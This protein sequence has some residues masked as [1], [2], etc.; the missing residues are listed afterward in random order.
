MYKELSQFNNKK[1][2]P[3]PPKKIKIFKQ[4]FHKRHVNSKQTHEK[5]LNITSYHALQI[6]TTRYLPKWLELRRVTSNVGEEDVEQPK[7]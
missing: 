1:K 3:S 4:T 7:L 2:H 5:V 6:K